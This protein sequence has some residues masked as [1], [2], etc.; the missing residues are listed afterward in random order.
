MTRETLDALIAWDYWI[1]TL[2]WLSVA[3]HPGDG[4]DAVYYRREHVGYAVECS[5]RFK[6]AAAVCGVWI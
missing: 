1:A 4:L 3:P 5:D 2:R 6:R